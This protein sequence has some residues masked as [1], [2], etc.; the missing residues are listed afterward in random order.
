MASES[1]SSAR[2]TAISSAS[3]SNTH[4]DNETTD[5]GT[6]PRFLVEDFSLAADLEFFNFDFAAQGLT[7][8][9]PNLVGELGNLSSLHGDVDSWRWVAAQLQKCP[10]NFAKAG[11]NMFI[12]PSMYRDRLP[13]AMKTAF[14]LCTASQMVTPATKAM[15]TSSLESEVSILL[16]DIEVEEVPEGLARLQAL[17][18][19][20]VLQF[21]GQDPT[22]RT[23]A[24][25][26]KDLI[27][28]SALRLLHKI[29]T[30]SVHTQT[31][32]DFVLAESVRRTVLTTFLLHAICS[33]FK[34]G[35]CTELPTLALLPVSI[36]SKLWESSNSPCT[37]TAEGDLSTLKY[38][39]WVDLWVALPPRRRLDGFQKLLMVACKGKSKIEELEL[40]M[41]TG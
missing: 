1:S 6:S 5:S 31:Y 23:A 4:T 10:G 39:E 37:F 27:N 9:T 13:P 28:A 30:E 38:G 25:Q 16:N 19:Y 2:S 11:E 26:H 8:T 40:E 35:V 34:H 7:L 21:L 33:I 36:E 20:Q 22:Q 29:R 12:H 3:N 18:M 14:G 15:F 24:E 41:I 32:E 17:L